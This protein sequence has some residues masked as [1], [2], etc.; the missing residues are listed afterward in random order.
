MKWFFLSLLLFSSSTF[1]QVKTTYFLYDDKKL[2][3]D[4]RSFTRYV[5]PQIKAINQ[6]FFLILKKLHPLH[7]STIQ[8]YQHLKE[9]ERDYISF[10]KECSKLDQDCHQS[11]HNIYQ[12]SRKLEGYLLKPQMQEMDF[13]AAQNIDHTDSLLHLLSDM[14]LIGNTNY[15]LMHTLE[16]Y[17]L[18]ANTTYFNFFDGKKIIEPKIHQMVITADLMLI[19]LL[20]KEL[21]EPFH[22]VWIH[23]FSKLNEHLIHKKDQEFL[24][25]RLEELNLAWNTFHMKMTKENN[26]LPSNLI[27]LIKIMHNRWN[28]CL[29]I[30]LR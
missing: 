29:K 22:A 7:E 3:I 25:S 1:S 11:L 14:T 26:D 15:R 8:I 30:I 4:P 21:K 19:P 18:T 20:T 27:K 12:Q 6:E 2:K 5:L 9:M 13:S 28:S 24:I 23:F 17:L 10:S 16:E